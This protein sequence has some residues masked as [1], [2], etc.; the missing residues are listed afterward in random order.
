MEGILPP[1]VQ[2]EGSKYDYGV[3]LRRNQLRLGLWR[4][5]AQEVQQGA[6]DRVEVPWIDMPL[7]KQ[8]M[9]NV[10]DRLDRFEVFRFERILSAMEMCSLWRHHGAGI[11]KCNR[12]I[13]I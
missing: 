1:E 4:L 6:W 12:V 5:L 9:L 2:W 13:K 11:K 10:P 8:A 7:L 3:E